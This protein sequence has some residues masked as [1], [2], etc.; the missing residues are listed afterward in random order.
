MSMNAP[1][2]A[3]TGPAST[4][5]ARYAR[6]RRRSLRAADPREMA[7]RRRGVGN[8]RRAAWSKRAVLL[9]RGDSR[10]CRFAD[11]RPSGGAACRA[12]PAE[13]RVGVQDEHVRPR[14]SA[15]CRCSLPREADVLARA[16]SARRRGT[17]VARIST[18]PS[19]EAL[20][21]TVIRSPPAGACSRSDWRHSRSI[22]PQRYET[23]TTCST[24]F[25]GSGP[26]RGSAPRGLAH[27]RAL[28][29]RLP[30][31]AV[32]A[33]TTR[34]SRGGR[35]RRRSP[36]PSR[37]RCGAS[38]SRAGSGGRGRAG[39]GRSSSATRGLPVSSST[40][41]AISSIDF[42]TPEPT[43]YV[44]P[45]RPRSSTSS[46]ALQWSSTWSHSRRFCVD[47]YS[48]SSLVVQRVRREERDDLLRELPR[49]VVVRAVRD[50][51]RQLERLVV[52]A[53][54]VVG[55]GLRRVVRR[56]RPVRRL[57][58]ERL[59]GVER[60]IAVDLARRDV[61]EALHAGALRR[62]AAASACR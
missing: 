49:P 16:Q 51:D 40:R 5:G 45:T 28:L 44:S 22:G 24:A 10:R 4:S 32:R 57:L 47:A 56:A 2:T 55:A 53:H 30:P 26:T 17:R 11:S 7:E 1:L 9:H 21:T 19:R 34:P 50:R 54:G 35:P 41:S 61:V 58:G 27:R 60:Q 6:A 3:S 20:S 46:I 33:R 48:G 39:R 25:H 52:R 18:V 12:S 31:V 23:I 43:L 29:E 15:G 62:L 36:A 59:V 38:R 37:A 13:P 42:S 8:D 14:L